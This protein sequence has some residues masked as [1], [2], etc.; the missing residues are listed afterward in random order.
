LAALEIST[1]SKA[2]RLFTECNALIDAS[3]TGVV[4]T[5]V[6]SFTLLK[7][8]SGAAIIISPV[9]EPILRSRLTAEIVLQNV[10][11]L[12]KLHSNGI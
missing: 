4:A 1:Q 7:K 8:G 9:G 12:F 2:L 10:T 6:K 5:V 11:S 3:G